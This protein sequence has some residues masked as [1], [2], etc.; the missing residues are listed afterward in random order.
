MTGVN[1]E[2]A[3]RSG[4]TGR[5]R[6]RIPLWR[7]ITALFTLSFVTVLGGILLAGV[8]AM[9][10]LMILFVLERAIAT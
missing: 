2:P 10:A 8:L 6:V 7:R 3:P 9:T 5:S 1:T 4:T